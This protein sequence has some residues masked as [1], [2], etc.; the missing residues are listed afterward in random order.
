M[1]DLHKAIGD[2]SSIRMQLARSTEFRGYGP[3][4]LALTG[5]FAIAAGAAQAHWLP[6]PATHIAAYLGIWITTALVSALLIGTQMLARTH[7][8]HSG[9]ADE[10]IRMAVEQFLP[11]AVA[12]ALLTLAIL[13]FVPAVLWML[14]G[15]WLVTFSLGVFSSCRFLPRP[16][17]AAGA[18]YLATGLGCIALAGNRALSPWT[19]AVAYGVGQLLVAGVL[20]FNTLESE[21]ES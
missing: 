9:L 11:S 10:M 6:D 4:T 2:I 1:N 3:V 17:L 5:L 7:R 21:D 20:F 13:L 15:L 14:P 8:I 19:M 18:W 16:M 12:G